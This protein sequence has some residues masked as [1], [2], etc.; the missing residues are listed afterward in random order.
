MHGGD[1]A[2][3]WTTDGGGHFYSNNS[4]ASAWMG[5]HCIIVLVNNT[6]VWNTAGGFLGC[7]T[8]YIGDKYQSILNLR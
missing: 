7:M 6:L 1:W 5:E 4:H 2:H 8:R 3:T